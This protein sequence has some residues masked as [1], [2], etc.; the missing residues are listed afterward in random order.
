MAD[1]VKIYIDDKEY[2]VPA[3]INLVDAAKWIGNDIPVFCYHPKMAPVGMCRM[4]L[5]EMGMVERDKETKQMVIENGQPKV[6]WNPKLQTACT[7]TVSDGLVIRTTTTQVQDARRNVIEFLLTSHP[8]DCPIC[9]KGGECPLQNLTMAYGPDSSRMA[10][11][12]KLRLDKHVPLGD[13][14]YLDEERC[15]QCARCI[16]FQDE[17]AGDDVLAF[18]E[19]GRS[20]QIITNS[21]P[22]FDSYFSGNTTD[23]CPVGALTTDDFRFEARPWELS[24]IPS[25]CP[26]C[27]VGCNITIDVRLERDFG[28]RAAIQRIMP[29][30]NES[31][32]EIWICDK[33]RWGHH[34]TQASE[35][36]L[37]PLVNGTLQSWNN[38]L[39]LAADKIKNAGG[40]VGVIAGSSLSN[41]DLW[42]LRNLA[43]EN[44]RLGAWPPTHA[45]AD[46][47]AQVGV[48]RGTN[49][50]SLG[51]GDAVLVIASDLEEEAPVWRLRIKQARDR[52]AYVV[53]A[54]ARPTRMDG[55][56]SLPVRYDSGKATDFMSGLR[57]NNA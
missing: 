15:I 46:L 27:P 13:L 51:K 30:Q 37:T 1:T 7:S 14:I 53:V 22:G 40:S 18:H 39:E 38:A 3:G 33:G 25:V 43:G 32:N 34:F 50:T 35:R 31:V 12:D 47:V 17:V 29:R 52:G 44:A 57:K 10:L 8:L 42:T 16:R 49:L 45:G 54:N 26:H 21:D 24:H 19:R 5:V 36:L 2:E 9:D 55:F 11:E 56:S 4:C 20:L 48:G 28:G 6:R 23:I 41:E